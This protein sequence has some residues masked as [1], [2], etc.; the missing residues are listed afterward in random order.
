MRMATN[1]HTHII[2]KCLSRY[3]TFNCSAFYVCHIRIMLNAIIADTTAWRGPCHINR[4]TDRPIETRTPENHVRVSQEMAVTAIKM[5]FIIA[6]A[7]TMCDMCVCCVH[8]SAR[9]L[10]S[11][12]CPSQTN[13]QNI[14]GY[15]LETGKKNITNHYS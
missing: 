8:S 13:R 10:L 6:F 14:F 5:I 7:T 1:R 3:T 11:L 15:V 9:Q 2:Y 12:F 4:P